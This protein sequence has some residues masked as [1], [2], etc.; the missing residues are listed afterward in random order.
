M[1]FSCVSDLTEGD[2]PK[3]N[4]V[5]P[6]ISDRPF[7]PR[8][9]DVGIENQRVIVITSIILVCTGQLSRHANIQRK[10]TSGTVTADYEVSQDETSATWTFRRLCIAVHPKEVTSAFATAL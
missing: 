7:R 8:T 3:E 1:E 4:A 2:K 10:R 6:S 9:F 5:V